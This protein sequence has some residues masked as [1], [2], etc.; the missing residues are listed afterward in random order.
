MPMTIPKLI[1]PE[2]VSALIEVTTPVRDRLILALLFGTG[3]RVGELVRT[4]LGDVD[5]D[6]GLIHLEADR[7]K[8]HQYRS[9][10]VPPSL[11]PAIRTWLDTGP[12]GSEWLFPGRKSGRHITERRVRQIVAQAAQDAGIQRVY[13]RDKNGRALNVV[14]P[15]TL[16]HSHAVAALD[17][18]VPLNDIQDQLGHT[19]LATTSVYL[20]ADISHRK[21]SYEKAEFE[22]EGL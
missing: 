9:V 21:R 17:A 6:K 20:R 15:H 12:D 7:T 1:G 13:A 8:T 16:R 14:S 10:L 3:A 4:K 18:G 5:L 11:V 19:N 2:D 22:V